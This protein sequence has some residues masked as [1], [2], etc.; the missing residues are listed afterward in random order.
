[1][2]WIQAG[3]KQFAYRLLIAL[4]VNINCTVM[5]REIVFS[6]LNAHKTEGIE[7]KKHDR[8]L[9]YHR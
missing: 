8:T 4:G 7:A 6:T 1:M 5:H 9:Q 2:A 3:F